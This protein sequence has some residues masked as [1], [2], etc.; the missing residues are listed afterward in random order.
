[1]SR[2][3]QTDTMTRRRFTGALLAA[4]PGLAKAAGFATSSGGLLA[5]SAGF[6]LPCIVQDRFAPPRLRLAAARC[7]RRP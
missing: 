3:D 1:M 5:A 6:G 7:R 2:R 4:A